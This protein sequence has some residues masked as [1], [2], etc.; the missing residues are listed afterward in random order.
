MNKANY[1]SSMIHKPGLKIVNLPKYL[2]NYNTILNML[3]VYKGIET[4]RF[5]KY[6]GLVSSEN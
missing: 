1:Y 6:T 5:P 4:S 2:A 3:N